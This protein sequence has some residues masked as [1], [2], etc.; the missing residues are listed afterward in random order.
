MT[1]TLIINKDSSIDDQYKLLIKQIKSLL[2]KEDNLL[3][4]L[5]NFTAA[6]NQTFEKISWV[7]FY[8]FDNEQLYLG[9]F[10]GKIACTKIKIGEGVCGTAAKKLEAIIVDDVNKFPGY[11]ACDIDSK[12]E[13]VLPILKNNK[14]YGVLDI[15]SAEYSSFN[16]TDRKYLEELCL[17]LSENIL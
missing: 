12:S 6:L 1:E 17:F 15:D 16:E 14:F 3:S 2:S 9:P 8:L 11:I 7:G 5:A 10:Q 4:N 13:I